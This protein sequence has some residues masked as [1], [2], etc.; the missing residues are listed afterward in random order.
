MFDERSVSWKVL[1]PQ[2]PSSKVLAIGL[3]AGGLLG[4]VRTWKK[5]DYIPN[6]EEPDSSFADLCGDMAGRVSQVPPSSNIEGKYDLVIV[7]PHL[8]K[9][10]S[11][12]N[13]KQPS[14]LLS[15]SGVLVCLPS[16]D[17]GSQRKVLHSVN[18]PFVS[19]YAALP[20]VQ[21]R[22][23]F[24]ISSHE[25][26]SR[27]LSFHT[28]GRHGIR[29]LLRAARW[30][31]HAGLKF[32]YARGGLIFAS[33]GPLTRR[34]GLVHWLSKQLGCHI[35]DLVVY[36]GSDRK[37]RKITALTLDL[38]PG[39]EFVVKIADTEAG[40]Q[41]IRREVDALYSINSGPLRV[42]IPKL[43]VEEGTWNNY[44]IQVQ[45]FVAGN[46]WR[47][48]KDL[49]DAHIDFLT[50]LSYVNRHKVPFTSSALWHKLKQEI[51]NGNVDSL[52]RPISKSID[53]IMK[54]DL[55]AAEVPCHRTHGDFTSWNIRFHN[56][57]LYAIDWED[58]E[59]EGLPFTDIACFLYSKLETSHKPALQDFYFSLRQ[60][61]ER[62]A[63]VADLPHENIEPILCSWFIDKYLEEPSSYIL[64]LIDLICQGQTRS[65]GVFD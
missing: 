55:V 51:A 62:L 49:T 24:P 8:L 48:V 38:Q 37:H 42:H 1:L 52:P 45:A 15:G 34:G 2:E 26:R 3:D 60:I 57:I 40:A 31:S 61:C 12:A 43:L 33:S 36:A 10:G 20:K 9:R 5:V 16:R 46:P 35:D 22:I 44:L 63:V 58:S 54:S 39:T 28:P 17:S 21:P 13:L 14:R 47:Q 18:L 41:A 23:Y 27:G 7:N 59:P 64:G 4:L 56:G 53:T 11:V 6:L 25:F 65:R 30:L 50:K 19:R 32:P 29:L